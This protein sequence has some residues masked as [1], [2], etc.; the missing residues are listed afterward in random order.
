MT[1]FITNN[2][3]VL[4]LS[5][6]ILGILLSLAFGGFLSWRHKIHLDY[7]SKKSVAVNILRDKVVEGNVRQYGD[8][9]DERR[10]EKTAI[11]EIYKRKETQRHIREW[12]RLLQDQNRVRSRLCNIASV[13]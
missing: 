11:E 7:E 3:E 13:N 5:G 9:T 6:S 4:T 10:R 1:D 8:I 2:K 12:A